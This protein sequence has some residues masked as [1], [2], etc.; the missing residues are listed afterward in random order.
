MSS[1]GL[2]RA[3]SLGGSW[4]PRQV[5]EL[6]SGKSSKTRS[7]EG[8]GDSCGRGPG[9]GGHFPPRGG[10]GAA[11]PAG[12]DKRGCQ[13]T[14]WTLL[15]GRYKGLNGMEIQGQR[16]QSADNLLSSEGLEGGGRWGGWGMVFAASGVIDLPFPS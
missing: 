6:A 5:L 9:K 11:A 8:E 16:G 4:K 15:G 14:I 13:R 1:K 7:D 3:S 2:A 12:C 10:R